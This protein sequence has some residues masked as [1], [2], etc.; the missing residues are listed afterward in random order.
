M[1]AALIIAQKE[2]KDGIRN[3]WIVALT[4]LLAGL[5]LSLAFLGSAPVGGVDAGRLSVTIVSLAS[6]T[7]FLVPLIA[8]MLSYDAIVGDQER[9]T[10]LLVLTYPVSRWQLLL[11]KFIGHLGIISISML[12]GYG[13]AAAAI[14]FT[15]DGILPGEWMPF[16]GLM[17]S[18]ILLGGA[19]LAVGYLISTL[20]AER[21]TAAGVA[22]GIWL[23]FVLIYDMALLGLLVADQGESLKAGLFN[24]LLLINPTDAFRLFNLTGSDS[25]SMLSGMSAA[26]GQSHLPALVPLAV[27][28]VWNLLPLGAAGFLF[29][30]K[31]I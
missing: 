6:L 24:I 21:S 18:S 25:M 27:L 16:A 1:T 29:K 4:I 28:F 10:L 13:L 22:V 20:V 31:E 12:A 7:I 30:R 17:A 23:I 5:A 19:F 3:R 14:A 2:L 11:G 15:G 26:A 8:L 9:G